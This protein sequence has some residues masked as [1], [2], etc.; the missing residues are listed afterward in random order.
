MTTVTVPVL[1]TDEDLDAALARVRELWDAPDGSPE[2]DELEV[3]TL[4]VEWYEDRHHPV[5]ATDPVSVV[6]FVMEQRGLA[7]ADLIPQLGSKGAVSTFLNG[8]RPLSKVQA[9]RLH[10]AHRIPLDL[11]LGAGGLKAA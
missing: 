8:R 6:R 2:A 9:V 7:P 3:L 4:L 10:L 1:R 5:P 11:L